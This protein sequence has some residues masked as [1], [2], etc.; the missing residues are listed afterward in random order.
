MQRKIQNTKEKVT[1]R[2]TFTTKTKDTATLWQQMQVLSPGRLVPKIQKSTVL[3][4]HV[5]ENTKYKSDTH[6]TSIKA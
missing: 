5:I 3:K 2:L 6:A 1:V 4:I